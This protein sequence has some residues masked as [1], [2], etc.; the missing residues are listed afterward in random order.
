MSLFLIIDIS[1]KKYTR[2]HDIINVPSLIGLNLQSAKDTLNKYDLTFSIIDS[3]AYNPKY[4]RGSILSHTP[5]VGAHVKPG[6]KIYLTLNPTTIHYALLPDLK[7]KSLR[8]G[9]S[10]LESNA[11]RVGDIHY[12]DYFAKDLIRYL[13]V[14]NEIVNANDSLPKFTIIDLYIG[15]GYEDNVKVPDLIGVEF[16]QIKRKLNNYS[17]NLGLI[18]FDKNINDTISSIVYKQDPSYQEQVPLGNY[19][20]VWL[21]DSND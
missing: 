20:S 2:H 12:V 4:S 10:L 6:R 9:I 5:K 1:L 15:D 8:H 17:L 14:N 7:N 13:K 19:V 11:F 3:A 21:K 18:N 16:S